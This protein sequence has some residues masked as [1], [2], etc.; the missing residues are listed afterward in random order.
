MN[1]IGKLSTMVILRMASTKG[2]DGIL[3]KKENYHFDLT[4]WHDQ[5]AL[6]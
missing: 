4:T 3:L 5:D 1:M 6:A 2:I